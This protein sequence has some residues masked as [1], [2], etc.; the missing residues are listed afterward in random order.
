MCWCQTD[1]AHEYLGHK[2]NYK[3]WIDSYKTSCRHFKRIN[4]KS[5]RVYNSS[6]HGMIQL[7]LLVLCFL[8]ANATDIAWGIF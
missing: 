7:I 2:I 6:L 8:T 3:L 1:T 4:M 5:Q